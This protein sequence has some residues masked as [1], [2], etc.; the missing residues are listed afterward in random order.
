MQERQR[1]Y[2]APRRRP[3]RLPPDYNSPD[4]LDGERMLGAMVWAILVLAAVGA[5]FWFFRSH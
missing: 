4:K 2:I 1:I 3:L 5:C